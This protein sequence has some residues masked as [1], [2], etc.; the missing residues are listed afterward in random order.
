[1]TEEQDTLYELIRRIRREAPEVLDFLAAH[2]PREFDGALD[3]LLE[4]GIQHLEKNAINFKTLDENGLTAVL[5]GCLTRP[6]LL[7]MQEANSNGHVDIT[8]TAEHAKSVIVRLAEAKM[9]S[10]PAYHVKGLDQLLERYLTGREGR[11]WMLTYVRKDNIKA[12]MVKIRDY[13]DLKK[14]CRQKAECEDHHIKWAFE[15]KHLH[16]SGEEINITHMGCNL[17]R[18]KWSAE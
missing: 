11:G 13:L 10:G 15:S 12:L 2:T 4:R 18:R 5:A 14:P 3:A 9:Y 8:I 16:C 1:M 17:F 6:W 7:V